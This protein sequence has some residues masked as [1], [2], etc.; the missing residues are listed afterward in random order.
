MDPNNGTTVGILPTW[1]RTDANHD[2]DQIIAPDIL[3]NAYFGYGMHMRFYAY[4]SED[5]QWSVVAGIKERAC[6]K[7]TCTTS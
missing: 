3:H 7:A 1:V 4:P 6:A 5:E 2:I